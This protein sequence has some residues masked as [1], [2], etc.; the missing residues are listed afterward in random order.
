MAVIPVES[1]VLSTFELYSWY[2]FNIQT[3]SYPIMFHSGLITTLYAMYTHNACK[4][5]RLKIF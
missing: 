5:D 2:D 4:A 1:Y 3:S